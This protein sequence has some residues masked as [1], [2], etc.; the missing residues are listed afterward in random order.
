LSI[1]EKPKYSSP[2]KTIKAAR[3]AVELCDSLTG[4]ALAKQQDRVRELLDMIEQQN[5][6]QQAKINKAAASKSVRSTKNAGS[7]SHGQASS[8]H[9]DKRKEKSECAANDY[10][11]SGACRKTTSRAIRGR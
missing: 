9:P 1:V 10:V 2:D 11:R 4:D 7:K 5:A 3:A 6:E 8:P